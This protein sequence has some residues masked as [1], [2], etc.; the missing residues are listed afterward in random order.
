[1]VFLVLFPLSGPNLSRELLQGLP[2]ATVIAS[3]YDEVI[4]TAQNLLDQKSFKVYRSHHIKGT[5]IAGAFK[6]IIAIASGLVNGQNLG[7]NLESII[8][9]K[10][11]REMLLIGQSLEID[12]TAFLGL[13]G[14]GDLIATATSDD[15]RN[16]SF[17]YSLAQIDDI[18][19][20]MEENEDLVEGITTT[21]IIHYYAQKMNL[22]CPV[23]HMVYDVIYN[24]KKVQ[25]SLDHIYEDRTSADVDFF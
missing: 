20:T 14:I 2:A 18:D 6:N 16:Y 24:K 11:L 4:L 12:P 7:K 3:A 5:E 17:G 19:K 13:A 8:L 15:S 10:G 23:V 25:E 22:N 1:M 9:T 21:A